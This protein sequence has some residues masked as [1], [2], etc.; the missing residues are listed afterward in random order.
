ME[1][2]NILMLGGKRCGKTTV[3]S[4]MYQ[5]FDNAVSCTDL[6][7]QCTDSKTK[8]D[9]TKAA[10]II[11]DKMG[12]FRNG[13]VRVEVDENSTDAKKEF[14]FQLSVKNYNIPFVIHDIPGEWLTNENQER[15]KQLIGMCEVIIIAIDTPY[16]FSKMTTEGYGI[17]HEEYN[18]P[19]E[20]TNFFKE[21][22]N[23]EQIKDKM[24]LFVPI[25]CERY[26]H[27]SKPGHQ[28]NR[29]G[30]KY[31]EELVLAIECGYSDL[32]NYLRSTPELINKCTIA[33]TPILSA[34][35]ID[36][37]HFRKDS[38]GKM[39][40]L[41]QQPEF[42]PENERGYKPQFCEQ[43]LLFALIYILHQEIDRIESGRRN[44]LF[45]NRRLEQ[46]K[47]AYQTLSAKLRRD[48]MNELG[49]GHVMIANPKN[50]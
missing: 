35:G 4:S 9:L 39:V 27:L 30:R 25:K 37:V 41:Y 48:K 44:A 49:S 14:R 1:K 46:M 17:Y 28:L 33:I 21:T 6:T 47:S 50:I 19:K 29:T 43:P 3:L 8:A 11:K 22:L 20:I 45:S 16:L 15:V 5:E 23:V 13:L 10:K 34:G 7:I 42:L 31:M 36:F 26:Y 24:I 2:V 12:Q 32:L 18:K 38:T 40:S